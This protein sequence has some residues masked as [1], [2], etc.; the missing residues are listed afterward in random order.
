ME[1]KS[2][3]AERYFEKPTRLKTWSGIPLK[4][5][6]TPDDV[7]GMDYQRDVGNPGEYP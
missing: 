4:E 2:S 5:T 3:I 1:K 7:K 6:Y